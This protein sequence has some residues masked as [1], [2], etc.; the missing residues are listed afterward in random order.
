MLTAFAP[1]LLSLGHTEK[2]MYKAAEEQINR[3]LSLFARFIL[4]FVSA[5]FWVVMILI[6]PPTDKSVFFH[7]FG[8]FCLFISVA[9]FTSG[10][11]RQFVGSLIGCALLVL[12][13]WYLYAELTGGPF[14]SVRRSEPSVVNAVAFF[15]AFGIPGIT[16]A[17]KAR[18]GWGKNEQEPG[19]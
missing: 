14:F 11:V 2:S 18:F 7:V 8:I 10:R 1:L 6:A 9:C 12:S 16:Y 4:G 15:V 13:G 3:G 19:P 17:I 5:L